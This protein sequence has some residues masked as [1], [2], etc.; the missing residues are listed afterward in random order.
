MTIELTAE[1]GA[2]VILDEPVDA[3]CIACDQTRDCTPLSFRGLPNGDGHLLHFCG[4]CLAAALSVF[5]TASLTPDA[6][7]D[8]IELLPR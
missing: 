1:R 6:V 2:V 5:V 4:T 7:R 8:V 3:Q